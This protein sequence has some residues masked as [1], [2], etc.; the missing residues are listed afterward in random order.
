MVEVSIGDYILSG[1]ELA[2]QVIID[3]CVRLLPE[4]IGKHSALLE[5]SFSSKSSYHHLLEYPHYTRPAEW[6]GLKVPE[7]LLS[8]HHQQINDWRLDQAEKIT[9]VRRPDLWKHYKHKI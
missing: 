5:E 1:G 8:G 7:V 9:E 3:S 4:V 6:N 2:A